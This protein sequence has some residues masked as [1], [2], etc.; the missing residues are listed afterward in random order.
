MNQTAEYEMMQ[1]TLNALAPTTWI[2]VVNNFAVAALFAFLLVLLYRFCRGVHGNKTFMQTLVMMEI[3]ITLVMMVILNVRGSSAVAVAFGLMGAMSVVR[4]RTIIKDNR[5]TAFVFMAV[6]LG[7]AAGTGQHRIGA[8]GFV[9]IWLSFVFTEYTPWSLRHRE[10]VAKIIFST[11]NPESKLD[12]G[13]EIMGRMK[14]LGTSIKMLHS[15][16]IK[17]GT[18]IE[19][20]YSFRLRFR[21]SEEY[22]TAQLMGLKCVESVSLFSPSEVEEP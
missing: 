7:M 19:A 9:I 13:A 8:I 10:I 12:S 4:F 15:R 16:T 3:I 18:A 17:S 21:V 1:W 6:A 11:E 22:A 14:Q 5:D 2:D 20:T